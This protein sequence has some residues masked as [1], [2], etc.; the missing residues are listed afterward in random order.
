MRYTPRHRA[1]A[2][3]RIVAAA[4]G[5]IRERGL[6]E[7]S[8][9][10]VMGRAGLTHGAFY[11]H[12][13]DREALLAEAVTAAASETG[14]RV[15]AED[16]DVVTM[17]AAYCSMEHAAAPGAGCVLAALGTEAAHQPAGPVRAAFAASARGFLQHVTRVL[18]ASRH[19]LRGQ[20]AA[21]QRG[22]ATAA[23]AQVDDEALMIAS[24]MLGAVVL[25]RLVDDER[26]AARLLAAARQ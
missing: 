24:R 16:A 1:E 23:L 7:S 20:P 4:S 3:A 8:V 10:H 12:F 21:Q 5:A 17:L 6:A 13:K 18:R 22:G 26:L 2:R 25:A 15:F 11:H 19:G 14:T 9:A